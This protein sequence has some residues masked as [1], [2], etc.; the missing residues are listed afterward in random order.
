MLERTVAIT[1]GFPKPI[2]YVPVHST[3]YLLL[4]FSIAKTYT[5]GKGYTIQELPLPIYSLGSLDSLYIYSK[6]KQ[7]HYRLGQ[8]LRVPGGS[9]SQISRQSAQEGG[10]VVSPTHRPPLPPPPRPGN[11]SGTHFC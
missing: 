7:S 9:A 10:K 11:I 3:V 2:T 1:N 6:V 8:A 4:S 5:Q